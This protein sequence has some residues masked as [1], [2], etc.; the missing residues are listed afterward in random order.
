MARRRIFVERLGEDRAVLRGEHAHHLYHVLRVR[1]GQVF[2][3][4]DTRRLYLGRVAAASASTVEFAIEQELPAGPPLPEVTLLVAIFKFDRLEWLVEKATEL[5]A[6]RLVP[7]VAARTEKGLAAAALK[8]A[9]RWRRIAFEAA[10][11][12]RRLAPMDIADPTPL[13]QALTQAPGSRRWILDE[14]Q[15]A[16]PQRPLLTPARD[17]SVLAVGP[18]GG[19][20][21]AERQR[22][23]QNGF[24]PVSLGPLIL[25]VETAALAALAVLLYVNGDRSDLK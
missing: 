4:S 6:A 12:C 22:A 11:Q 18:E 14:H 19:W 3:L 5:G 8:R 10:Q 2:E 9:E 16:Q 24:A 15:D 21:E 1:P 20:T 23:L 25:R 7:I 17:G 13:D